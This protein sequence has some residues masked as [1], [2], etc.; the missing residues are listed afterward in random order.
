MKARYCNLIP[1]EP[2]FKTPFSNLYEFNFLEHIQ[3]QQN[4][5]FKLIK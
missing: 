1:I 3:Q 5:L 4:K 2:P